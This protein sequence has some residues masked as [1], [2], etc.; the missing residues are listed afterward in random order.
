MKTVKATTTI[1]CACG[2][3]SSVCATG[4]GDG[5]GTICIAAAANVPITAHLSGTVQLARDGAISIMAALSPIA[6][7]LG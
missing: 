7:G 4:F 5:T 1:F 6:K 2:C 3:G